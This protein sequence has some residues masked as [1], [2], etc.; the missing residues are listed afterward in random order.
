MRLMVRAY[1]Q[2]EAT[3]CIHNDLQNA[4]WHLT[5]R[6]KRRAAED[7]RLGLAHD[8]MAALTVVAFAFEANLNFVGSEVFQD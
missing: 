3:I 1:L 4:A 7:D 2:Y 5:E 6:V 8:C